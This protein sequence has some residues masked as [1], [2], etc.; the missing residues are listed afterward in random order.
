MQ[1]AH[2]ARAAPAGP[3]PPPP[4]GHQARAW[5][6]RL[7]E[8]LAAAATLAVI[9]G[10]G[11]FSALADLGPVSLAEEETTELSELGRQALQE[12][13]FAYEA[14]GTVVVPAATDAS[15]EWTHPVAEWLIDGEVTPLG[16][17]G[18]TGYT[19]MSSSD[20]APAWTDDLTSEDRVLADVGYLSLACTRW[21]GETECTPAVLVEHGERL[22]FHRS[23]LGSSDF[24]DPGA[25]MELF[26]FDVLGVGDTQQLAMGG[27]GATDVDAVTVTL[28]DG[29][30]L[31]ARLSV[32]EAVPGATMWWA[33]VTQPVR[34]AT[35]Y[36][37]EDRVVGHLEVSP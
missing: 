16:V 25:R 34:Y 36:D 15:V 20:L 1:L 24:L 6:D 17:R 23:G 12:L 11:V 2:S 8:A 13:P 27:L 29:S 14:G 19:T 5:H 26:T 10:P 30:S 31:P 4:T 28:Q 7:V 9:A 18:L 22:Y 32:D 21:P 35:A 33:I 37:V 3:A